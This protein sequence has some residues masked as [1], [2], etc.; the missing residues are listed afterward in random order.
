[1]T[2]PTVA[3]PTRPTGGWRLG[4]EPGSGTTVPP[5]PPVLPHL[6]IFPDSPTKTQTVSAAVP[7]FTS[8]AQAPPATEDEMLSL[9]SASERWA[10]IARKHPLQM[11]LSIAATVVA[12][13]VLVHSFS[14]IL[15]IRLIS[16]AFAQGKSVAGGEFGIWNLQTLVTGLLAIGLLWSYGILSWS[17]S[18]SKI[19]A[20]KDGIKFL[21]GFFVGLVTGK[22]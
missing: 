18:A 14:S 9:L 19:T 3:A 7:V 20:A 10:Y 11:L 4:A 8:T 12:I 15:P 17:K 5:L 22:V 13:Y 6:L 16:V 1:M 2:W 21:H